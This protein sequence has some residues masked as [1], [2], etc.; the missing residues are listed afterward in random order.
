MKIYVINLAEATQRMN[1]MSS[2]LEAL[3]LAYTRFEAIKG[4]T[5]TTEQI[6]QWCNMNAIESNPTWLTRGA[7]GCA[8]SHWSVYQQIVQ[9]KSE[10][11]LILE[12]DMLLPADFENILKAITEQIKDNEV[13]LLYFQSFTEVKFSLQQKTTLYKNYELVYPMDISRLGAAGAYVITQQVAQ[14]LAERI[15]PISAAA[16]TWHFFHQRKGFDTL[17]CVL[18]FA[19]TSSLLESTIDYVKKDNL[20]G[21]IKYFATKYNL[22]FMS[23][24]LKWNR[25]KIWKKLTKY[26]FSEEISPFAQS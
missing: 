5:L 6:S 17:R 24:L 2:Q 22:F 1:L 3:G 18:P 10:V 15:F 20:L 26:S 9:D 19:V 11:S 16:D 12:D 4:S 21:K 23:N 7:I 13:I 25:K 8:L 14:R